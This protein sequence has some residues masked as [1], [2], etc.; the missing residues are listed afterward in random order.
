MSKMIQDSTGKEVFT[1][2][3]L[4]FPVGTQINYDDKIVLKDGTAPKIVKIN[5][6]ED[7]MNRE[8]CVVVYLGE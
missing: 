6:Q 7:H 3:W 5:R 4:M 1:S 8:V 2:A